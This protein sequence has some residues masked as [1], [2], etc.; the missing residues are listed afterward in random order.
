MNKIYK[1]IVTLFISLFFVN[2]STKADQ[3]KV[4]IGLLVPMSGDNKDLG[5]LL[6]KASLM[7]LEDINDEKLE[8]YP[9]DTA[10]NPD[11]SLKSAIKL[12]KMGIKIII[13]PV[14]YESLNYLNDIEDTIYLSF[15]NKTLNLPKNVISSGVNSTSQLSSIKK[16]IEKNELKK[17][18]IFN[19]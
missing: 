12:K 7:A 9:L 5:D 19:T 16:F 11:Q 4:K 15:T 1:I 13:G 17:N 18:Y 14:F 2:F 3:E 6:I 8:I 10:S